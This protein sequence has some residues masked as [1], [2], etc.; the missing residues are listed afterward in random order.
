MEEGENIASF[1]LFGTVVLLIIVATLI[2]YTLYYQRKNLLLQNS[3]AEIEKERQL[4]LFKATI[5]TQENERKRIATDIHDGVGPYL[6]VLRAR[7]DYYSQQFSSTQASAE[8]IDDLELIDFCIDAI[9]DACKEL[10]PAFLI[11]FG[12]YNAIKHF[13]QK[14]NSE[15]TMVAFNELHKEGGPPK[16]N[17]QYALNLF[18]VYQEVINNV[19][20]HAEASTL[21]IMCQTTCNEISLIINHNGIKFT[22]NDASALIQQNKGLGLMNIYSRLKILNGEI[23]YFV[24]S[25]GVCITIT[26]FIK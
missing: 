3:I 8:E 17:D 5:A 14:L 20:K 13:T 24:K 11:Q 7:L 15:E 26:S 19:L 16:L 18:R 23:D 6:T 12:F 9:R 21:H 25:D 2:I 1:I 10:H 22:N 4:E